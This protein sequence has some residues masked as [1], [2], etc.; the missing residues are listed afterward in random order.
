M[1]KQITLESLELTRKVAIK[2]LGALAEDVNGYWDDSW[3][4]LGEIFTQVA[5]SEEDLGVGCS[6]LTLSIADALAF[7]NPNDKP[8][9]KVLSEAAKLMQRAD[10][11]KLSAEDEAEFF[12][13]ILDG[14]WDP[15]P[16]FDVEKYKEFLQKVKRGKDA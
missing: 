3:A 5:V 12:K 2:L 10:E 14:N 6:G 13:K 8:D 15:T 16:D 11:E 1:P 9:K 7:T 4:A